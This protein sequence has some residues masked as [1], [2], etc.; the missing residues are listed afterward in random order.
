MTALSVCKI[1]GLKIQSCKFFDKSQVCLTVQRD[2]LVV[3]TS[4]LQKIVFSVVKSR[5][6]L[7]S[8]V[9]LVVRHNAKNGPIH[10][11]MVVDRIQGQTLSQ[12]R[13]EE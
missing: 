3:C 2:A 13:G 8:S 1:F 5:L 10:K 11:K 12:T 4:A 7:G 9:C 6:A